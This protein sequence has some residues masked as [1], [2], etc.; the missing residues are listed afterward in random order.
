MLL[1]CALFPWIPTYRTRT[2][3][4]GL[5]VPPPPLKLTGL[6]A[7]FAWLGPTLTASDAVLLESAGLDALMMTWAFRLGMQIFGPLALVGAAV[8]L[9]V[10]LTGDAVKTS[11]TGHA[12]AAATATAAVP[13]L[14]YSS[15]SKFTVTNLKPGSPR[16]WAFFVFMYG[17]AIYVCWLLRRYY[18]A[19]VVLR[20]R[21]LTGGELLLSEWHAA[22]LKAT[23][24]GGA[25]DA[26]TSPRSSAPL[27][28]R[29][30]TTSLTIARRDAGAV[31]AALKG[32]FGV[33]SALEDE[34]TA[35]E[36]GT[37][38]VGSPHGVAAA[39]AR[40]ARRFATGRPATA[41]W[42]A[43]AA[44][45]GRPPSAHLARASLLRTA[46]D[47]AAAAG[48]QRPSDAVAAT[49]RRLFVVPAGAPRPWTARALSAPDDMQPPLA[50]DDAPVLP[51]RRCGR[52]VSDTGRA[53]WR[54]DVEAPPPP[55]QAV[56]ARPKPRGPRPVSL[57]E[58]SPPPVDPGM[59]R[60]IQ[61]WRGDR[62]GSDCEDDDEDNDDDYAPPL[63]VGKPNVRDRKLVPAV[64]ADGTLVA[65]PAE[66][67]AVLVMDVP[68]LPAAR[69]R[70]RARA[71]RAG[72]PG[73]PLARAWDAV[74]DFVVT[75]LFGRRRLT[76]SAD[77]VAA[78]KS[79]GGGSTVP[80]AAATTDGLEEVPLTA[81]PASVASPKPTPSGGAGA[82]TTTTTT[83]PS[84]FA[85]AVGPN[86]ETALD[87]DVAVEPRAIVEETFRRLF[88]DSFLCAVPV[89]KHKEVDLALLEWDKAAA[90]LEAA[91]AEFERSSARHA[92]AS[93]RPDDPAAA[94]ASTRPDDPA[95]A[96]ASTRPDD[97][98]AAAASNA[99]R[100]AMRPSPCACCAPKVDA[101]DVLAARVRAAE[102]RVAAERSR[103]LSA[104][105]APSY[106]VFFESQRDAAVAAQ[107]NL[108]A[109]DGHSFRVVDAPG[110][111][112]VLWPTLW[113]GWAE[114][115]ARRLAFLPLIGA[116]LLIPI[117][118]FLGGV[119]QLTSSL[120]KID[121][122][123]AGT[124]R[125]CGSPLMSA[126]TALLPPLSLSLWN[127]VALPSLLYWMALAE[128]QSV[129][130]SGVD[131]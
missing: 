98:A 42:G 81:G 111:E 128:G 69:A 1:F 65:A 46:S 12:N 4:P 115:D 112:D 113:M 26:A 124:G 86:V 48:P 9:P 85:S 131:R 40:A 104:C 96:A 106:F 90:A 76:V 121:G 75:T 119:S 15:F 97:P 14:G 68:D 44:A 94:A 49:L 30:S 78:A 87:D 125:L 29:R 103:A 64:A 18:R 11:L 83:T 35:A 47:A 107:V 114:R 31:L 36:D 3:L 74:A 59:E 70:A 10:T 100:P 101:I 53:A 19:Y 39:A 105:A 34:L 110:P 50:E 25:S 13:R 45:R 43:G 88:P 37:D 20:Q 77:V 7:I 63:P 57:Y 109:E 52:A 84:V 21:Y 17:A 99:A 82:A 28:Y 102:A 22:Y 60:P 127:G 79:R 61:W 62:G 120:C 56:P 32:A 27:P 8:L 116:L 130:L 24:D 66:Q 80:A 123:R 38:G 67:Y 33:S 41:T 92:T 108:Q 117:G 129:S 89:R 91:E 6:G 118:F 54:G 72:H 16:Y 122:F 23:D 58:T 71:A 51:K 126:L 73:R 5:W 95:A 2:F 93:T 55:A